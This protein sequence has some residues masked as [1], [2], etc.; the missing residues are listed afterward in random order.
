MY[1]GNNMSVLNEVD[2]KAEHLFDPQEYDQVCSQLL[3]LQECEDM[4]QVQKYVKY[5]S[6]EYHLMSIF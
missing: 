3:F 1:T 6:G 4:L 2:I 5:D